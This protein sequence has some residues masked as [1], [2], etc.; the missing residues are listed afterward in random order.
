MTR[1]HPSRRRFLT[2]VGALAGL[3]LA[4]P[5]LARAAAASALHRWLGVALGAEARIVLHH[6]DGA[7]ARR[8]IA[9]CADEIARLE[10]IFSLYRADSALSR[11]NR[12]GAL[13][14]PPF[15]LVRLLD[16]CRRF[17]RITGGAFDATV[18]P[19]WRLYADHF[20]REDADPSGPGPAALAQARALVD[21]RAVAVDPARAS[22]ARPGM[23][24]TLNGI[25]QGF[26]TDRVAALLRADGVER[27]LIDLGEVRALGRHPD[28][29]PWRVGLRD[30]RRP[31]RIAAAV[32]LVDRAVATSAPAAT[33]FDASGAHHHLFDPRT[34]R[35]ARRALGVSVIAYDATTADALSTA[36]CVMPEPAIRDVVSGMAGVSARLLRRSG[37]TVR[38]PA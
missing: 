5:A 8:L 26:I 14:A 32:D 12:F 30:P 18:Q 11:L 22:F 23:A 24:V 13:E 15:A 20:S 31:G 16:D 9:S 17:A 29:R 33:R 6:P 7:A 36:F 19:L 38:Y 2:V 34:G 37:E 3:S 1:F 25:A 35:P 4:P 10:R 27:V 21:Q 28:G